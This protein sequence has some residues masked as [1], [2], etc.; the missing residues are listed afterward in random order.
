MLADHEIGDCV[1]VLNDDNVEVKKI[2]KERRTTG[3]S[4]EFYVY[5][6]EDGTE[7]NQ[8]DIVRKCKPE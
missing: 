3:A 8:A 6:F 7:K 5:V 4:A 1:V 2:V